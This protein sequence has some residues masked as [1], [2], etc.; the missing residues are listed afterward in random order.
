MCIATFDIDIC[1]GNTIWIFLTKISTY[2]YDPQQMVI[3][4]IAA[5]PIQL[6]GTSKLTSASIIRSYTQVTEEQHESAKHAMY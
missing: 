1:S 5:A 3:I 4:T 2:W 6:S